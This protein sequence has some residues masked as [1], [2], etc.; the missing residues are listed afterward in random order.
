MGILKNTLTAVN[1]IKEKNLDVYFNTFD[2]RYYWG[3]IL[4][5][6][7]GISKL[8]FELNKSDESE[9]DRISRESVEDAL[10]NLDN[11][12]NPVKEE[13]MNLP[14][15]TKVDKDNWDN[16][17]E[18]LG[19]TNYF[20]FDIQN[21]ELR[22]AQLQNIFIGYVARILNPGCVFPYAYILLGKEGGEGKTTFCKILGGKY[23]R[24][25]PIAGVFSFE[26]KFT[27]RLRACT[28]MEI[29]EVNFK[30]SFVANILKVYPDDSSYV[31]NE[32][33]SNF[34]V[35]VQS[36]CILIGTTNEVSFKDRW[37]RKTPVLPVNEID[38]E[39]LAENVDKMK[40]VARDLYLSQW[41]GE[42][43]HPSGDVRLPSYLWKDELSDTNEFQIDRKFTQAMQ[44]YEAY[45]SRVPV[46]EFVSTEAIN[47]YLDSREVDTGKA[48]PT[49][50]YLENR[51]W[52]QV[53][54]KV[55]G[56]T[57]LGYKKVH[58][59]EEINSW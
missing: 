25:F 24:R 1:R 41:N 9:F 12:R 7:K 14:K 17:N 33:S 26:D 56:V 51:G 36:H 13:I 5:D 59:E 40:A 2:G 22:L 31:L 42:S 21:P 49:K 54:K 29:P 18:M 27:R 57:K 46:N 15:P 55:D 34:D 38:L 4:L 6:R 44:D 58:T 16:L 53:R 45:L 11:E 32:K 48:R 52:I 3:D 28:V 20:T 8:A 47:T 10:Y 43:G 30:N 19:V 39:W 50:T 23:H 37:N 35:D